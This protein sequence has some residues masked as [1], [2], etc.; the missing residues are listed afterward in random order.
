MSLVPYAD[1]DQNDRE[2]AKDFHEP[3]NARALL[4]VR[5]R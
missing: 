1:D 3:L 4:L 5:S 2:T